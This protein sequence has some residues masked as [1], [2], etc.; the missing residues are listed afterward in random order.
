MS[1]QFEYGKWATTSRPEELRGFLRDIYDSRL[2][3]EQSDELGEEAV[4]D[5]RYQ[6]FLQFDGHR[7][8]ARNYV[9]FIQ[10][11]DEVIEIYPKVFRD[12]DDVENN[13]AL[14]LRHLFYWFGYCRKWRFPYTKAG[15]ETHEIDSFPE[16]IIHLMAQQFLET[17]S[18]Q[19]LSIYE[20]VEEGL[21]T[22][23]G[24]INFKRY[25]T[26]SFS[27]GNLH[28]VD[29]DYEPFAFNN[30]VNRII[31]HCARLLLGQ[32]RLSENTR[33]LQETIFV[34]DDVDD[35]SCTV[36]DVAS[37]SLNPFFENYRIVL[38]ICHS[39]LTQQLYSSNL[40]D[41]RQW[42]LLFPMEYI[43]EDFVAGFLDNHFPKDW[44][45]EYQKSDRYLTDE[46]KAFRMQ[47][48]IFLTHRASGRRLIVDTKYKLRH[49][50]FK[51]DLKK[52]IDQSDLYQMTAYGFRRGCDNVLLLYPNLG[53]VKAGPDR[54]KISSGF[55]DG[56]SIDVTAC[57][58]PFWSI[59]AFD[60][61]QTEMH[62]A[63][64]RLLM[65]FERLQS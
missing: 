22:P 14:M 57:E 63:L 27:T 46:P 20:P 23:R 58:I 35:V 15:L 5:K 64:D 65:D 40:N 36:H 60:R 51:A 24:S 28:I 48:D 13:K 16:L 42:C 4:T 53:E 32:T 39:I 38:D 9:G 59:I 25:L 56:T 61:L 10:N 11:D 45:V 34:L 50:N 47:H 37:S 18:S 49:A 52:G 33:L 12:I 6:P 1:V 62:V 2:F 30:R 55:G 44:K 54:F 8:R 3:S 43:F 31:K 41:L 29:C 21:R 26:N 17:V 19:P 7:F